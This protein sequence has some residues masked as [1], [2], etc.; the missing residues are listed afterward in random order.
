ME[1][2]NT[3]PT[4][5]GPLPGGWPA[6][7]DAVESRRISVTVQAKELLYMAKTEHFQEEKLKLKAPVV[8]IDGT[9]EAARSFSLEAGLLKIGLNAVM[10]QPEKLGA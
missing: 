10:P 4:F 3:D 8:L 6:E 7:P 9:I 5:E 2:I 1:A